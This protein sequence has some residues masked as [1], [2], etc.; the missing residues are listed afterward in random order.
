[1]GLGAGG[2]IAQKIYPDPYGIQTW[3]ASQPG[4][5]DVKIVNSL[6]YEAITGQPAPHSPVS[7]RTY[8]EYGLPW[9]ELYDEEKGSLTAPPKLAGVES[10]DRIDAKKGFTDQE[11]MASTEIKPEQIKKLRR[12]RGARGRAPDP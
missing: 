6:Q 8:S 10:I 1:M 11:D 9:F 7:A 3:E 4:R 5:L 12:K 2:Q